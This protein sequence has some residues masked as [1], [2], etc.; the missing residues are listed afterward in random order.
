MKKFLIFALSAVMLLS[1]AGCG[2]FGNKTPSEG[3]TETKT[4]KMVTLD[5]N[6]K[7]KVELGLKKER[8]L[9][10]EE[11]KLSFEISGLSDENDNM[12]AWLAMMPSDIE[13]NKEELADEHY[14]DSCDLEDMGESPRTFTAPDEDGVYDFRIYDSM[15][16]GTE[17]AYITFVVGIAVQPEASSKPSE[18]TGGSRWF[19]DEVLAEMKLT[20]FTQPE[21][22]EVLT[23]E[24]L[25]DAMENLPYMRAIKGSPDM[26]GYFPVIDKVFSMLKSGYDEVFAWVYKADDMANPVFKSLSEPVYGDTLYV[27]EGDTVRSVSFTFSTF[28]GVEGE[29]LQIG[30]N[31]NDDDPRNDNNFNY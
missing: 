22:F 1:L 24:E 27:W 20:G 17:V 23:D 12:T 28:D 2:L 9:P 4:P 6:N 11:I 26:D 29:V 3:G 31:P 18:Q 5:A 15:W 13:H 8:F 30:L 10:G 14:L 16:E 19:T 7:L 25:P 21:D